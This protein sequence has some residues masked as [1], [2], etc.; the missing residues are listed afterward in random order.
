MHTIF[1]LSCPLKPFGQVTDKIKEK[2][3]FWN[4]N[5]YSNQQNIQLLKVK[6]SIWDVPTFVTYLHKQTESF[7]RL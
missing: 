7:R 6:S 4:T 1:W 3:S 2:I 5:Y